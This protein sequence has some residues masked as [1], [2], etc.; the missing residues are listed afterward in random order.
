[1]DHIL[2][3]GNFIF[4]C[5]LDPGSAFCTNLQPELYAP[6]SKTLAQL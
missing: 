2:Y 6:I 4:S 5:V 3:S 1:M